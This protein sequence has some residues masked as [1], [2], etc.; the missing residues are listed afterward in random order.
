MKTWGN[1]QSLDRWITGFDKALRTV[2]GVV[3]AQRPRPQSA[4]SPPLAPESA[5]LSAALMRVNHVGEVCAQALYA[6]QALTSRDPQLQAELARSAQEE[7]DH[8]AW[9]A[10]RLQE[11]DGRVSLLNPLWWSGAF[12]IGLLAGL[13]GD[14]WRLGFVGASERQVEG[15]L[16][17]HLD[18][19]PAGAHG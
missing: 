8:L 15:L 18:R 6:A 10:E 5:R 12:G 3:R 11:L 14:R 16:G 9:C 13:A 7:E 17:S 2:S 19:L 1:R 4:S